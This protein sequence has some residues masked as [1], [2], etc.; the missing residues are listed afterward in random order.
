M[1]CERYSAVSFGGKT[2]YLIADESKILRIG[3]HPPLPMGLLRRDNQAI[4]NTAVTQLTEYFNGERKTL[5]FEADMH[6]LPFADAVYSAICRIPYG[7]N[8]SCRDIADAV[9]HP[10][11]LTAIDAL[12][13]YNPLRILIPTHRVDL[14][15]GNMC[16]ADLAIRQMEQRFAAP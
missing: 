12:C 2:V 13:R 1:F 4:L 7:A 3:Y 5:S 8:R 6:F 11:S 10:Q 15:D 14:F 16:V 9:G